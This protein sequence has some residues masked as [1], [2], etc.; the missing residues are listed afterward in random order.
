[1]K[2]MKRMKIQSYASR[3]NASLPKLRQRNPRD[4]ATLPLPVPPPTGNDGLTGTDETA[5]PLIPPFSQTND[6]VD[7]FLF[8]C[9]LISPPL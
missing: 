5:Q 1:M 9:N 8:V 4:S 6:K 2:R 7:R 3:R